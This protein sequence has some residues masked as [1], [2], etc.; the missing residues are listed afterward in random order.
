VE[1]IPVG[2]HATKN[3]AIA[4]NGHEGIE[5]RLKDPEARYRALIENVPAVTY[6]QVVDRADSAVHVSPQVEAMLGYGPEEWLV[7]REF[8]INLLHPEDRERVLAENLRASKRGEPFDLEYRL[9][10]RDGRTAW[11]R[12]EAVLVRDETDRPLY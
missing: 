1:V 4:S 10:A 7:D 12:D 8:F 2:K 9:I 3:S 6:V 5:R 11:M